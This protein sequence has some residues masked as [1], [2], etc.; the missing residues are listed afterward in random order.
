MRELNGHDHCSLKS[1]LAAA[2]WD[3][4]KP[5]VVIAHTTK[6]KGVSFMENTV[7]WHY[8]CPDDD[9]LTKAIS[10]ILESNN[11]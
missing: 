11:A 6:G 8:K 10:E 1:T 4:G 7:E 3:A 2:P 5:S 9:Q